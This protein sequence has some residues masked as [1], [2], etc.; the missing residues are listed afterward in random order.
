MTETATEAQAAKDRSTYYDG[1]KTKEPS[2]KAHSLAEHVREVLGLSE[3]DFNAKHAQYVMSL[4]GEWQSGP[5]N[6]AALAAQRQ[7][8]VDRQ[9]EQAYKREHADEI[10]AQKAKE[11]EDAKAAKAAETEKAKAEKAKAAEERKTTREAEKAEKAKQAEARKAEREQAA[12]EK[13]AAKAKANAGKTEAT[14]AAAAEP[15]KTESTQAVSDL[16]PKAGKSAKT[17]F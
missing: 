10:R 15:A 5:K 17:P 1:L 6:Q 12:Q 9:K 16:L 8:V 4:H 11:R 14:Q 3:S 2:V 7:A 13:A